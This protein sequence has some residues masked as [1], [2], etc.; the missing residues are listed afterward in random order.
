MPFS[1]CIYTLP[2]VRPHAA[3]STEVYYGSTCP[4]DVINSAVKSMQGQSL[5]NSVMPSLA[6][7]VTSLWKTTKSPPSWRLGSSVNF[8][9]IFPLLIYTLGV[10]EHK[11]QH[12]HVH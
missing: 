4:V 6:L 1:W 12:S 11:S 5:V 9:S 2:L 7:V 8:P 10:G 3:T